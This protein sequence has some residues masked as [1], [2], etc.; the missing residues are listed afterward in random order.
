MTGRLMF[1]VHFE[2]VKL[3][4]FRFCVLVRVEILALRVLKTTFK[5]ANVTKKYSLLLGLKPYAG[6]ST[7][8]L[9]EKLKNGY[10]IEKP[11]GCSDEM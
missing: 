5:T 7:S 11:N 4:A 6:D 1:I 8:E 9:I 10:R 3:R 2:K